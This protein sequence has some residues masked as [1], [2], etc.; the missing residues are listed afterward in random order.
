MKK[1]SL[2][3]ADDHE[4]VRAGLSTIFGFQNDFDVVGSAVN[5]EEAV[6]LAK[7]LKPD[8]VIMDLVMPVK[9]GVDATRE[10]V[11]TVP[12]TRVLILTTFATSADLQRALDAGAAGA[13]SKDAP[14]RELVAAI[15]AVA[16]GERA[17]S[18]DIE[19]QLAAADMP[20]LTD[21]QREIL[22]ALTRG[23]SNLDI[24]KMCGISE[25]GVKAHM[26]TLFAKLNVSNR[27][28]AASYALK[29]RLVQ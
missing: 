25:D 9:D 6:R 10:I 2:L 18:S 7:R 26:K 28:E 8:V 15:R 17:V 20:V 12:M 29:H 3:I 4:V 24:A 21:R 27:L 19:N 23:L 16:R 11:A 14:N 1:I 22:E 5:G 13:V